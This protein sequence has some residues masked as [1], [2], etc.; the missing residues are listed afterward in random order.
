MLA[1]RLLERRLPCTTKNWFQKEKR[2][3]TYIPRNV[4]RK[5]GHAFPLIFDISFGMQ[6]PLTSG[7]RS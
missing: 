3:K 2:S 4:D 7:V 5:P 6:Q 1:Q